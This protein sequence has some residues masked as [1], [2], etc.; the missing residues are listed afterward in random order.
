MNRHIRIVAGGKETALPNDFSLDLELVNPLFNDNVESGS[1]PFV[2]PLDGNRHLVQNM[3]DVKSDVRATDVEHTPCVVYVDDVPYH[4]GEIVVSEDQ[5]L[6]DSLDASINSYIRSLDD[7]IQDLE[8]WDV[9]VKDKI[10]IGE[11]LGDL[12]ADYFF[13]IRIVVRYNSFIGLLYSE[14]MEEAPTKIGQDLPA[15][16]FSVPC[17]YREG[18]EIWEVAKDSVTGKPIVEEDFINVSEAYPYKKYCNARVCYK[19][20]SLND[21]GKTSSDVDRTM[22]FYVLDAN[23]P[24]SGVCFYVLY[25][26]DCLFSFLGLDYSNDKLAEVEDM[27]RLAFYTTHCEY[28]TERKYPL[29][30]SEEERYDLNSAAQINSWLS[31][32]D[33][34]ENIKTSSVK[35]PVWE[36]HETKYGELVGEVLSEKSLSK[37]SFVFQRASNSTYLDQFSGANLTAIKGKQIQGFPAEV[38]EHYSNMTARA[39]DSYV[40]FKRGFLRA[41]IMKMYANSKNF[42]ETSVSNIIDSLWASFG[43]KFILDSEKKTVTPYY[44]RDVLRDN[45]APRV[46]R[47]KVLSIHKKVEKLTGFRMRYAA[48]SDP[49]EQSKNVRDGVRDYETAFNYLISASDIVYED[50]GGLITYDRIVGMEGSIADTNCYVDKTTGDAYRWKVDKEAK[51]T[52][53]A[54]VNLFEVASYKGISKGDCSQKNEDYIVDFTSRFE[55]VIFTDINAVLSADAQEHE[56]VYAAY[57]EED[58]LNEKDECKLTFALGSALV[59][60]PVEVTFNTNEKWDTSS[61]DNGDSPLSQYDWGIAVALMRGGGSDSHIQ[62]YDYNYDGYGNAKYRTVSG[63]YAMT[64]DSMDNYGNQYDYVPDESDESTDDFGDGERFSLKITAYKHDE[65]GNPLT[66][67]RGNI[68]CQDDIRDSQGNIVTKIRSRGLFDTFMGEEAHFLLNRKVLVIRMKCE[69]AE[70]ADIPYHWDE[71]WEIGEVMGWINKVKTHVTDEEGLE[72]VEIEMYCL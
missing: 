11:C 25:F 59:D 44:I 71:R 61:S 39:I 40:T 37:S 38:Y 35:E 5:E 68:L 7:L 16:G 12:L 9:P 34:G 31:E 46:L 67:D 15:V 10:Q 42:P 43:I 60:Y 20:K 19:H 52:E 49:K 48:E 23:R 41:N 45:K 27:R 24:G 36:P 14:N 8:C 72:E 65:Q 62:Y 22:P 57:A 51:K 4:S 54:K 30:P 29:L 17:E 21:D 56:N 26:L 28:D 47:G 18:T 55:P 33:D 63:S 69:V 6:K 58:M 66:D 64:S 50:E 53:E 70:L 2:I 1:L 13:Y 32:R 3:E